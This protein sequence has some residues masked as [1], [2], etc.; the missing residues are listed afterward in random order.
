MPFRFQNFP[1]Y[2]DIKDFIK[3][4]DNSI[5]RYA[6]QIEMEIKY[7]G[8]IDRQIA[9]AEQMK[10][11]EDKQIPEDIDYNLVTSISSES[12]E[13]LIQIRPQTIGQA[14]RIPG[15]TPADI[16]VLLIYL[17]KMGIN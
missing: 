7:K 1:V 9:Q 3:D 15:V 10:K 14:G 6:P 2:K 17:K 8:Y 13:K 5:K 12:R 16:S 4:E 11:L